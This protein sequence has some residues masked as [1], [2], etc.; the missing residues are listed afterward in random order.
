[1]ISA[2]IIIRYSQKNTLSKSQFGKLSIAYI[3]VLDTSNPCLHLFNY[4]HILQKSV[5]SRGTGMQVVN[6]C[7]FFRDHSDNIL[8]SGTGSNSIII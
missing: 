3:F 2:I 6:P 1:M 7:Y 4:N 5:I 8:I